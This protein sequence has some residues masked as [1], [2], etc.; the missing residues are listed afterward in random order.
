MT[1]PR[2]EQAVWQAKSPHGD[3]WFEC[4]D[5]KEARDYEQQGFQVRALHPRPADARVPEGWRIERD[6]RGVKVSSPYGGEA[7]WSHATAKGEDIFC[8]LCMALATPP[9]T[10]KDSLT[11]AP[12]AAK[13]EQGERCPEC[14]GT[15]GHRW[16]YP[17]GTEAGEKC[18]TCDGFGHVD[19]QPKP[20]GEAVDAEALAIQCGAEVSGKIGGSARTFAFSSSELALFARRLSGQE[21]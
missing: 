18:A 16:F 11:T 13:P 9:A 21:G 12:P 20:A 7:I 15:G 8:D 19:A 3:Y 10:V 14:V 4:D 6:G 1:D 5:E 17:D 2:N